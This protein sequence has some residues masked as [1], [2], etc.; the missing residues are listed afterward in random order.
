LPRARTVATLLLHAAA[1]SCGAQALPD[2]AS[3]PEAI[4]V[5][6]IRHGGGV[7][8]PVALDEVCGRRVPGLVEALLADAEPV[9]LLIDEERIRE[10][11]DRGALEIV[12][13]EERRFPTA[14]AADTPARRVLVPLEDPYWVGTLARP[15]VVVFLGDEAYGSGPWRAENGL[16]FQ[17][18]IVD[19]AGRSDVGG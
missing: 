13:D 1:A 10:V 7:S 9:R 16:E 6:V 3:T 2:A 8:A 5:E 11:K 14:T 4:D 17:R 15:F 18:A 19:C 12:Y